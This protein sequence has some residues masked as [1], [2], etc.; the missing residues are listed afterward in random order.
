MF[1]ESLLLIVPDSAMT[2]VSGSKLK[3]CALL[4]AITGDTSDTVIMVNR[5]HSRSYEATDPKLIMCLKAA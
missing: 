5:G 1:P 3:E 2:T 4:D